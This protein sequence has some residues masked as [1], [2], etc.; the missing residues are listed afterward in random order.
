QARARAERVLA[1]VARI[2]DACD[3]HRI[4]HVA[5]K[6]A[7]D[8]PDVGGDLDLLVSGGASGLERVLHDLLPVV[9][10]RRSLHQHLAGTEVYPAP[11]YSTVVDV[12]HGRLGQLGEHARYATLLLSRRRRADFGAVS[13]FIPALE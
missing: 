8:F 3:R 12:H 10:G 11:E 7:R 5:L 13:C 4:P 6:V 2:A 1:L 9:P